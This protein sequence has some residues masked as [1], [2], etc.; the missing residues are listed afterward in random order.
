MRGMKEKFYKFHY[1]P[2][3]FS[4]KC[5]WLS[6]GNIKGGVAYERFSAYSGVVKMLRIEGRNV[7]K[8][9]AG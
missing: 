9:E 1:R 5:T 4:D 2:C 7:S 6:R 3:T 8:K